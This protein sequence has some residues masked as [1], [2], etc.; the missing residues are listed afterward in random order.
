MEREQ[1]DAVAP[2]RVAGRAEPGRSAIVEG[3]DVPGPAG[4]EVGAVEAEPA[5]LAGNVAHQHL[6]PAV[7]VWLTEAHPERPILS[8]TAI[9]GDDQLVEGVR[10]ERGRGG[11]SRVRVDREHQRRCAR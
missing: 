4:A 2:E 7:I 8:G 1:C 3:E 6:L 9:A 11:S 10:P 5:L